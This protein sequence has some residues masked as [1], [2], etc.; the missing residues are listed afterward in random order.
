MNPE[1]G[2]EQT[3]RISLSVVAEEIMAFFSLEKGALLTT[4]RL[5]TQPTKMIR[6]YLR[7]DRK[8]FTNPLRYL[9]MSTAVVT[10]FFVIF[11]PPDF[12]AEQ[13]KAGVDATDGSTALEIEPSIKKKLDN[14][15]ALLS[16]IESSTKN[17]L[18]R[19]NAEQARKIL[20][21]SLAERVAEIMLA[22][23]NAFLLVT[24]PLNSFLCWILFRSSK[25]NLAE[26]IVVNAFIIGFQNAL[27]IPLLAIGV[28]T[29]TGIST[30]IYMLASL[31]YQFFVWKSIYQLQGIKSL[32]G[33]FAICISAIG[34]MTIQGLVTA[35]ILI[36][37]TNGQ[38]LM[39]G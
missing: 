21:E 14:T 29:S 13:V 1:A 5:A 15:D 19:L 16:E 37:M 35:V 23:M 32:V 17:R 8:P 38:T 36:Y 7:G 11:L 20:N 4:L 25:F 39:N 12:Y 26:H 31:G 6:S 10:L 3:N 24:L 30:L 18:L 33:I 9:A 34:L 22:C 27:S 28:L 2:D